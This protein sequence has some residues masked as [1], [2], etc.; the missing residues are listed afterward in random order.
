[1]EKVIHLRNKREELLGSAQSILLD[2]LTSV[3]KRDSYSKL[4]KEVDGIDE[5]IRLHEKLNG[6][7]EKDPSLK[8][9]AAAA[10]A[11]VSAPAISY[12]PGS[13]EERKAKLNEAFRVYLKTE[14]YHDEFRDIFTGSNGSPLIPQDVFPILGTVAKYYA[15]IL[16]FV[17]VEL[18]KPARPIKFS[19]ENDSSNFLTISSEGNSPVE[20]DQ[21]Y[22]DAILDHDLLTGTVK[23]SLQLIDDAARFDLTNLITQAAGKR[24]GRSYESIL[25]NGVDPASNP[26]PHNQGLVN[27]ASVGTTST[28]LA[29]GIG[30]G[31]LANLVDSLDPTYWSKA[32]FMFSGGTYQ[33]LMKQ[34]DGSGRRYWE[35]LGEGRLWQ[36]PVVI[37]NALPQTFSANSVPVLFGDLSTYAVS[38][39]GL[40]IQVLYERFVDQ[41]KRGF[42]LSSRIASQQLSPGGIKALKLAAA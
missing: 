39:T 23:A 8:A 38:H 32:V 15:P 10:I 27:A 40:S 41:F 13:P 11:P 33:Y 12:F 16:D 42:L 25:T 31:D 28:S 4:L 20:A 29:A 7:Y 30:M 1:M 2:G 26:A 3:E 34:V 6:F 35:E 37:N 36:W 24:L 9:A 14:K 5:E 19:S 17:T 21:T 18:N 22:S